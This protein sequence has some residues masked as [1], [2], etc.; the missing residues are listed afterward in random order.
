MNLRMLP[1]DRALYNFLGVGILILAL[2]CLPDFDASKSFKLEFKLLTSSAYGRGSVGI[3][4]HGSA[5]A[6]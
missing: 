1:R 4:E 2:Q 5:K 3:F 6:Y